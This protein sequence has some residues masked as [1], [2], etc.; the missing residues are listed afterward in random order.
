VTVGIVSAVGRPYAASVGVNGGSR[1]E[2]MIQ[3]D[4]AINKG[5]SGGPL[6]NVRGEVIG[7]NTMI[8]SDTS[9]GNI[10][11]GFAVPI[12]KVH[13]LLPQLETGKVVR[14]RIGVTLAG[15]RI[16]KEDAEDLALPAVGGAIIGSVDEGPARA[17][18]MK[19]GDVVVDFNGK[20]VT[21][22]DSLIAMVTGTTPGTTV[23]VK[24]VRA[25]KPLTLNVKVEELDLAQEQGQEAVT[26]ATKQTQD[27]NTPKETGFGMTIQE[28]TPGAGRNLQGK[29]G[30][31][32]SS[33][34]PLGQAA[35]QGLAPGDVIK[36]VNDQEVTSLDQVSKALDAV[37]PGRIARLVVSSRGQARLI[38]VRR[39]R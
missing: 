17:A 13:A 35:Q 7:I 39:G 23:P 22:N 24:V 8:Y 26:T 5:N 33:V 32:I 6:L 30:A 38:L 1:F 4:A 19:I 16:T 10:G 20:P 36:A 11:I 27:R 15:H 9:G 37:Q 28:I 12:N 18:G 21:D 2:E 25:K 29:G 34:D 31:V 14:G 3:T